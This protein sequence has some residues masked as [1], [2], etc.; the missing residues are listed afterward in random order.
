[1]ANENELERELAQAKAEIDR[2]RSENEALSHTEHRAGRHHW[3]RSTA[4]VVLFAIGFALVPIAGLAVWSRNTLLDTDRYVETV[5]PLSDDPNVIN[6]VAGRVTDAI[7]AQI[8]V[9]AELAAN[10][11]PK[12]T[13]A[14]GPIANQV[15]ST[16]NDLVVKALETDQFD[17]LW[18]EVNRQA[19]EAIVAYVNGDTSEVLV[20]SDDGQLLLELG[21]ILD[22]VKSRL[23]EQGVGIAA[24]I[25]STDASVPLPVGDVSYLQDLKSSLQ[26][27][28][29]LA[30]VLPWLA[31]LFFLGAIL[32][33]Q[34]RRRGIVW[35]GLLVAGG[36]LLVGLVLAFGRE[37]YLDAAVAGGADLGT[38]ESVFDTLVRF[39]RNGIRVIFFF[40][41]LL[42][43]GAAVSGPSAWA[44]RT[45]ELSGSLFTQ[46]GARTGWD[47]G[48]FG[49]FVAA[50]R[51]GLQ[52]G[53]AG[54]FGV[55]VF[56]VDRPTPGTL[57]WLGIALL[58][59]LAAV[60]FFAATAPRTD[61][62]EPEREL[63]AS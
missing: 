4:V 18:R 9:E 20:I 37:A 32:L 56:L 46:G 42:A 53:A 41:L 39:L 52:L 6:S 59:V 22:A 27:L 2:L 51:K 11:P 21:P 26:L 33:S 63:T 5:A 13:F 55:L 19:S 16:T 7:F 1:M 40:G 8:D 45:R 30:F 43:F 29:T 47:T 12:L 28:K 44:T 62:D 60:Q 61:A 3:L 25:P 49:A 15:E 38:A 23:L 17:T 34:D 50:H 24:K 48:A 58:V 36:A 54:L 14:A 31:L 57:L 10:L 35:T